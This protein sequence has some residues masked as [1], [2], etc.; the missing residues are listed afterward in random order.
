MRDERMLAWARE[1][2]WSEAQYFRWHY[3]WLDML[4]D[5]AED[6]LRL[7]RIEA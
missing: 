7:G 5:V 6:L 4:D 1:D 2:G 3:D